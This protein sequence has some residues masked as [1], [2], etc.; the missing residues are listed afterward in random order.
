[1]HKEQSKMNKTH[2]T[3]KDLYLIISDIEMSIKEVI[4]NDILKGVS[5][6]TTDKKIKH[7]IFQ[8][9]KDLPM[10][11]KKEIA[12]SSYQ[13]AKRFYKQYDSSTNQWYKL[14]LTVVLALDLTSESKI[15]T[16]ADLYQY[17]VEHP[18][19]AFEQYPFLNDYKRNIQSKT[20]ELATNPMLSQEYGKR[21]M[22]LFAKAELQTRYQNQQD[23]INKLRN[24]N[25][26]LC[27]ISSHVDCSDRCKPW[28][29]K[30]VDL[31]A[32]PINSKFETGEIVD[33]HKVYSFKAITSQKDKYGYQ[34][35]I[36]VGFNCRHYLIP[37]KKNSK[38]PHHYSSN[39]VKKEFQINNKM[40][41]MEREI[42]EN[43][44]KALFIKSF[45]KNKYRQFNEMIK[46][47][48]NAYKTF[49]EKYQIE[50]QMWRTKVSK[51]DKFIYK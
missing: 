40:R 45:N 32:P 48:L 39:L 30:L 28:Q 26:R 8:S 42:R 4:K 3:Y 36:I 43:R 18:K 37:Y 25:Q 14:A 6:K 15:K 31:D 16:K 22:S 49:A 24:N 27:W 46:K 44:K 34:N 9:C 12:N 11:Y 29:G 5:K 21:P 7:I 1:M 13:S 51:G 20:L 41:A 35:N 38:P 10:E 2:L 33:G 19:H 47:Q 50:P 23:M 17:L